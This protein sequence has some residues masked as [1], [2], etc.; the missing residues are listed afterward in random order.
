MALKTV[1][2][3]TLSLPKS[4][5]QKLEQNVPKSKRSKFVAEALEKRLS[6]KA[7]EVT[8]EEVSNFWDELAE[9]YPLKEP[10]DKTTEELIRE[11]RMSH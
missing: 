11:D 4:T 7:Q 5:I 10:L 3:I 2:R 1:K 8:L 6:G 9:K